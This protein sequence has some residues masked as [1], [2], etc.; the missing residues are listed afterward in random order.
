MD[1]DSTDNRE[2]LFEARGYGQDNLLAVANARPGAGI[3]VFII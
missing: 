1:S 3:I 2:T